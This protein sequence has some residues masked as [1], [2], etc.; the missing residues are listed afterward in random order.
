[1][2]STPCPND[3]LRTV[4]DARVP[5]RC[6]PMTI[7]S[8]IWIRSLSPSRTFTCTRT[9]SPDLIA[10]RSVSCDFSTSSIAPMACSFKLAQDFLLFF[11]Q[12]RAR[13]EVGAPVERPAQRFPL[14]P[15]TDF[16]VVAR[17]QHVG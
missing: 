15:A 1:M 12:S 7:P 9:V 5:P 8:K 17:Q 4:N 16:G 3:T 6:R 10:G 11:V 13:Q 2:R 14:P